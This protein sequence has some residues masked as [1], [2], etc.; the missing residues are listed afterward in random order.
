MC[1]GFTTLYTDL[2]GTGTW[3][4]SN[5]AVAT[6]GSSTGLVSGIATGTATITFAPGASCSVTKTIT[7]NPSPAAI[8]GTPSVCLGGATIT[9]TDA[10]TGGVW[11]STTTTVATIGSLSGSVTAVATGVDTIYYTVSGCAAI[12][13]VT[14]SANPPNITGVTSICVGTTTTLFDVPGGTWSSSNPAIG[15]IDP[16][17]GVLFGLSAGSPVITFTLP[18]GCYTTSLLS[19]PINIL[20]LP[21]PIVGTPLVCVGDS[22]TMTEATPGGLWSATGVGSAATVG[23]LSGVVTGV[24]AGISTIVYTIPSTGCSATLDV[25][26]N[27]APSP[28]TGTP[29]VCIGQTTVLSAGGG[30]VWSSSNPA[31]A[32]VGS[33]SGVVLGITSGGVTITC[34]QGGC[35]VTRAVTV[36]P[37]PPA[38][39]GGPAVCVGLSTTLSDPAG[40][41]TWTSGTTSVATIG[42]SSGLLSGVLPGTSLIIYT[43]G[44]TGCSATLTITVNSSPGSISGSPSA[45]LGYTTLY[46]DATPGGG[47]SSSTTTVATIGTTGILNPVTTGTTMVTYSLGAGCSATLIVTVN[48]LPA[49]I[50]GALSVCVSSTTTLSD[51]SAGG[52]W[53]ATGTAATVGAST[54]VVSGLLPGIAPVTYT[55]TT[56]CYRTVNVTVNPLPAVI[57]GPS[58]VCQGSTI[59][60]ADITAG[61]FWSSS[62]TS[63]ASVGSLSGTVL[64]IAPGPV[65]ISYILPTGCSKTKPITVNPLPAAITG[66]TSVCVGNN[67]T[68]TDVT[69]GGTWSTPSPTATVGA[70]TGVVSGVSAGTALIS[71]TIGTGCAGTATITV[72]PL[73]SAI[74]GPTAV[75]VGSTITEV[76]PAGGTW[77]SGTPSIATIGSSSGIVTGVATG[78]TTIVYVLP[79]GCSTNTTVTVSVSPVAIA[80]ASNVCV[81]SVTTFTDLV[82]GGWWSSSSPTVASVGSLT[83]DVS[84][85]SAGP[86]TITYSLGTGCTVYKSVTVTPSPVAITGIPNVCVGALTIY[87]DLTP[88]GTW[89]SSL[90][91]T[92]SV[93]GSGAVSGVSAGVA[94]ISY[95]V[96]GC[97]ATRDVTVNTT[98]LAITGPTAVCIGATITESDA[99]PGGTWS[100]ASAGI[101]IGSA[102]GDVTGVSAGPASITYGIGGC[103]AIRTITVSPVSPISG[104][105]GVC[106]GYTLPLSAPGGGSWSSSLPGTASVGATSGIVTGITPGTAVITYSLGTGCSST[107]TITVN[108]IPSAISGTTHACQG[109]TSLLG[110]TAGGGV[111][112]SSNPS[113]ANIGSSSG[114]VAAAATGT[115]TVTYSLGS[116]C[117]VTTGFT[118]NALPA[119]ISG[120]MQVCAGMNTPLADVTAG[121][122]WSSSVSTTASVVATSGLVTGIVPGTAVISYTIGTGCAAT[123][124]VTVN[125]GAAA[126]TGPTHICSGLTVIM[127]D[128]TPGGTWSSSSTSTATIVPGTGAVTG[129]TPGIANIIYTLPTGCTATAPVTVNS[130]PGA[131]SGSPMVCIGSTTTLSDGTPGGTWLS[132]DP[133]VATIGATSGVVTGMATGTA[134]ISYSAGGCPVTTTVTVNS[135]PGSI[136]GG[137]NVCVG[138]T[139]ALTDLPAGGVWSSSNTVIATIGSASGMVSGLSPG[140]TTIS[141]SLGAGCTVSAVIAVHPAPPG[142]VGGTNVCI[143]GTTILSDPLPGGTWSSGNTSLAT[144]GSTGIVTGVSGGIV[145]IS[146]TSPTTGCAAVHNMTVI[147]VAPFTI[148]N[149]CAW[150]DTIT[151]HDADTAGSFSSTLVTVLNTGGGSGIVTGHAPGTATITYSLFSGCSVTKTITVNPLPGGIIGNYRICNGLTMTLSDSAA[152][153]VWSSSN[154]AIA[155][156]GPSTG[157]VSAL[158][159]GAVHIAYTLA[160]GCKV[161]TI[162]TVLSMPSPIAGIAEIC[163]GAASTLTDTASGGIW[164]S[165]NPGVAATGIAGTV[166]GMS[167]GTATITYYMAP[168]CQVT[169][170]VTIDPL[171]SLFT[172]TGGGNYCA[173]GTGLHVALSGS[174]SGI[175]YQLYN[176]STATG[177][178]LT[179]TGSSID[180]GLQTGPGTYTV[181]AINTATMCNRNMTGT[182]TITVAP[183]VVPTVTIG[184][185]PATTVCAGT[186][187]TFTAVPVNGGTS[188]VYQWQVNTIPVGGSSAVYSYTPVNGDIVT[189]ILT[190]NANCASPATATASQA[191]SVVDMLLPVVTITGHPGTTVV[192]GTLDTLVAT[193][194]GAGPTPNYQWYINGIVVA[195]ATSSTFV[196]GGFVD[197]DSVSCIVTSNGFCGGLSGGHSVIIT[198][199]LNHVG[200]NTV[201]GAGAI[202]VL[203]NPNKGLFTIRGTMGAVTDEEVTIELTNV[204]GQVVCKDKVMKHSG[205]LDERIQLSSTLANGMYM[206]TLKAATENKVF[207]IVIEQ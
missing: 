67:I 6:V 114:L 195:G 169:K 27:N 133:S 62:N 28:I 33:S 97:S 80:G 121:G 198:V 4:S 19:S 37:N 146:Y 78:P 153:G 29:S 113:I 60:L 46:S 15:S 192:T 200:V 176:G 131:I 52:S 140:S 147:S 173:G 112:T 115:V 24:A 108:T 143:A 168:S 90:A 204:L 75:C 2:I 41:G 206:L 203:P 70:T 96:G 164:S 178:P 35:F 57:T 48:P 11:S 144:V 174:Q 197:G 142:I 137:S 44:T 156:I 59:S 104:G 61:G 86:A 100:T 187:V 9:Y 54:G 172:V 66:P 63:I 186:P 138:A 152:G 130:A 129:G 68:L 158:A 5:T 49:T 51:L 17:T 193:A 25:T 116:G 45:C 71:Y 128:A 103:N 201:T 50:S 88:S 141:Y 161:D 91:G 39:T 12:K 132:T 38:I 106:V 55:L 118:V 84:G 32:S 124:T 7:V 181:V 163:N 170:V 30:G 74:T 117:N 194:T 82:G 20:P 139:V 157:L 23:S 105:S 125:P 79:T 77:T 43:A 83:G 165:S 159:P 177:T 155:T 65:V 31:I 150:G 188:P 182:A 3:S 179:G 110:N 22:V 120:T 160:T 56:G 202:Q 119:S 8:S 18:T 14:V 21:T 94:T 205:K 58:T 16:G 123:A 135:L 199:T 99:T 13:P 166:I 167:A 101:T 10:T 87:A 122:T 134:T 85:V 53:S 95:T 81:G 175:S 42:S 185:T 111:W 89:S 76:C 107:K 151:I 1:A 207:H 145:P 34:T 40:P 72:N 148:G 171:P 189:A 149:M 26:V 183:V 36:Y 69:G 126:I 184:A 162:V 154:P 47:W 180:F 92:A 190:S 136:S 98:P 127:S 73:P 191:M 196:Y 64:G 109:S 102:T 93:S